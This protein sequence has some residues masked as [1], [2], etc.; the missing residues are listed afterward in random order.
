MGTGVCRATAWADLFVALQNEV[1]E[2]PHAFAYR[3]FGII[4]QRG[5]RFVAVLGHHRRGMFEPAPFAY[6]ACEVIDVGGPLADV[7]EFADQF[8]VFG[9]GAVF[10][11]VE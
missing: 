7:A 5:K 6:R 4:L 8:A 3:R 1:G 10:E 11:D 2:P 9:F